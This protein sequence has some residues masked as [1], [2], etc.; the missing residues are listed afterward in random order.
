[1]NIWWCRLI[2]KIQAIMH[3]TLSMQIYLWNVAI[4]ALELIS[5]DYNHNLNENMFI[6]VVILMLNFSSK[7]PWQTKNLLIF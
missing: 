5:I 6:L 1:M 4:N 2:D 3:V 7:Y